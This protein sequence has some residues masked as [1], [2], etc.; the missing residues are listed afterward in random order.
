VLPSQLFPRAELNIVP[1]PGGAQLFWNAPG[2]ILQRTEDMSGPWTDVPGATSPWPVPFG[3][4][5]EFF[6]LRR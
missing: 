5:Q 2:T 4:S 6:R 1:R 3:Y